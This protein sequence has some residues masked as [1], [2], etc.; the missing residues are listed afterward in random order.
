[1]SRGLEYM[2]HDLEHVFQVS[3]YKI[4]GVGRTFSPR[5]KN[6]FSQDKKPFVSKVHAR[7]LNP[8]K[9]FRFSNFCARVAKQ[10]L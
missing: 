3:E 2:F 9:L 7:L 10:K 4:H 6:I 8:F 5:G 1:M